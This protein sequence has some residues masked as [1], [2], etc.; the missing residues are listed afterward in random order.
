MKQLLILITLITPVYAMAAGSIIKG[1]VSNGATVPVSGAEVILT[2]AAGQKVATDTSG[3]TGGYKLKNIPDGQYVLS[4][5]Q[6]ATTIQVS[7]KTIRQDFDLS[8]PDGKMNWGQYAL[9]ETLK[10]LQEDAKEE[11]KRK[12]MQTRSAGGSYGSGGGSGWSD[13]YSRTYGGGVSAGDGTVEIFDGA[14]GGFI[15]E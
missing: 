9:E 7:G 11:A 10:V 13:E 1:Y 14:S 15:Y 6:F 2:D 5:G 8:R 3:W 12:A 4:T